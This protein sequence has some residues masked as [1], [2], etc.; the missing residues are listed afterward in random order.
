MRII[1]AIVIILG[2]AVL[3]LGIIFVIEGADGRQQ[4][5]DSIAPVPLE[6]L[7]DTYDMIKAQYQQAEASGQVPAADL[8]ALANKKTGLG[9]ARA[10]KGTATHAMASGIVDIC[11][12]AGLVLAGLGLLRKSQA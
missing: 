2:L 9:L 6:D 1:G 4:V 3:V 5:A 8:N 7:D 11:I 10:N 12:G